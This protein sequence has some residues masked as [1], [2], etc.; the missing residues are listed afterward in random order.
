M[1]TSP[2][3]RA[4]L[5]QIRHTCRWIVAL[6]PTFLIWLA[7]SS[8]AHAAPAVSREAGRVVVTGANYR[9]AFT[10]ELAG[11]TFQ[12]KTADGEWYNVAEKESDS[13]LALFDGGEHPI[14]GQRATWAIEEKAGYVAVGQQAVLRPDT[15]T[16]LDLHLVCL[17]E[18]MLI[19]TRLSSSESAMS[20]HFWCP[21]RI[22][23]AP[24]DWDRYLFWG[25]D[26][27]ARSGRLVDLDPCPAYVGVSPWEQKGDTVAKLCA[28]RPAVAVLSQQRNMGLAVVFVDYARRWS[29]TCAFISQRHTPSSP[30]SL[31][32]ILEG[33]LGE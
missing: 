2:T 1:K 19:G 3:N 20:G 5:V 21:P 32:R 28:D 12:L 22:R 17:D 26:G 18:G 8:G 31:W 16:I 10:P 25:P 24:D 7:L 29:E 4:S 6:L 33:G 23:L 9:V 30:L 11:F 14:R 15:K 27:D 13:T